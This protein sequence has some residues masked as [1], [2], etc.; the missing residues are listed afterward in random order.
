MRFVKIG[1]GTRAISLDLV[2]EVKLVENRIYIYM[3]E[4]DHEG[5]L[6]EHRHT[7]WYTSNGQA[8]EAFDKIVKEA[9]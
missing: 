9:N 5:Y 6:N 3:K 4:G 2:A 7:I 1:D 8:Q